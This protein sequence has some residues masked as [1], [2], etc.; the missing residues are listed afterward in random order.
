VY[1]CAQTHTLHIFYFATNILQFVILI[2]WAI[3]NPLAP[4]FKHNQHT[5]WCSKHN[6]SKML[7][8]SLW[9]MGCLTG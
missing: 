5:P 3:V 9:S 6:M 8:P 1:D 7:W 4:T 2:R